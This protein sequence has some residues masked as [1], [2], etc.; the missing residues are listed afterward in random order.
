MKKIIFLTLTLLF[1]SSLFAQNAKFEAKD[2]EINQLK[3]NQE[4]FKN[5]KNKTEVKIYD[6]HF[7]NIESR[8][9]KGYTKDYFILDKSYSDF[10]EQV[11]Q[12]FIKK[13]PQY[14]LGNPK[15]YI[16]DHNIPNASSAGF[17]YYFI[18][19][20]IIRY[21]DNE[22]QLAAVIGH[23]IAH[24]YLNHSRESIIQEAE[25]VQDFKKEFRS[26][27][28]SEMIKLI[29][30]QDE[31]IQKKYDLAS[32]S[33]K[34]EIT[35]DSLG[36]VFYKNL[37]YPEA[38]YSNLLNKLQDLDKD[39]YYTIKDE[40]Y[41]ELFEVNDLKIKPKWLKLE[42]N[43]L[44]A[45][46]NFT[47]HIDKDSISSHPNTND[48]KEWLINQFKLSSEK[49]EAKEPSET[50]KTLKLKAVDNYYN[51]LFVN[52][53][54]GFALYHIINAK[55]NKSERNDLDNNLGLIF[56]KLHEARTRHEFNKYIQIADANDKDEDYNRFLNFVWNIPT[57]DLK[58]LAEYYTK[59]AAQ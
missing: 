33:R 41:Y 14:Q 28:R 40:T 30:S 38:E 39:E 2:R 44:F 9:I 12:S 24:N 4:K 21:L 49:T 8:I 29:K 25:F 27:K 35:A 23:E 7:K 58:T 43:E 6:N 20:G 51:T 50:Y 42:K 36:F 11:F 46:L 19:S 45:G 56:N 34:K 57:P 48:R 15:T 59:K 54:Y 32:Q 55:Q 47:E 53:Y 22:Y 37:G 31:V 16:V 10:I 1:S 26:L 13:N 3:T 18:N 52:D 17:D 5:F